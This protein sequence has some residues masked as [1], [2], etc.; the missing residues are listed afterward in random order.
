MVIEELSNYFNSKVLTEFYKRMPID[1]KANLSIEEEIEEEIE[2]GTMYS[3]TTHVQLFMFD[4][5]EL[6]ENNLI[7]SEEAYDKF[8]NDLLD[9]A[10]K[11]LDPCFKKFRDLCLYD[12]Q[13]YTFARDDTY[14]FMSNDMSRIVVET[15]KRYF[16][17]RAS[18]IEQM[19]GRYILSY[20]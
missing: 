5:D 6:V 7:V 12:Q 3:F 8:E 20:I 1:I 17:K 11:G 19:Y 4:H 9:L 16:I 13:L 15:L 18:D 2:V 14:G 10:F